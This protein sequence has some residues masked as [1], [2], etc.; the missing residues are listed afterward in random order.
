MTLFIIF[1]WLVHWLP[2][3]ILGRLGNLMGTISFYVMPRRRKITLAN[4]NLCFPDKSETERYKIA[5]QHFQNYG[6]SIL[7]RSILWSTTVERVKKLIVVDPVFP[8]D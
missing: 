2:L 1:L 8:M 3:P 6:R 5:K 7:E 4:L